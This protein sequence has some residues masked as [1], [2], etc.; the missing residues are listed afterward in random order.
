[1]AILNPALRF[2]RPLLPRLLSGS[3]PHSLV[4]VWY[5]LPSSPSSGSPSL[6]ALELI[7]L[8]HYATPQ[9]RSPSSSAL[10]MNLLND[11]PLLSQAN[12]SSDAT[13]YSDYF[14]LHDTAGTSSSRS[15]GRGGA[16]GG[17]AESGVQQKSNL[18]EGV[19]AD[20]GLL[21]SAV[22]S[23]ESLRHP[24]LKEEGAAAGGQ[25]RGL[26]V[27]TTDGSIISCT[28]PEVSIV[29]LY[30]TA[31]LSPTP[32]TDLMRI[33]MT[34]CSGEVCALSSHSVMTSSFSL[35]L[36]VVSG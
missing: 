16:G 21:F 5:D 34:R 27:I 28:P 25:R 3:Q 7:D 23:F 24:S 35:S 29:A 15:P 32:S 18:C 33:L 30:T 22:V 20:T 12:P 31:P 11:L 10:E 13:A 6:H 1:V 2:S 9:E 17:G 36:P 19:G 26:T 14:L 4:V 8:H